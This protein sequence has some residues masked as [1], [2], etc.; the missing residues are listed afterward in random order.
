MATFRDD[1]YAQ[2]N[3]HVTVS[4]LATDGVAAGFSEVAGLGVEVDVIEYRNGNEKENTVRK[5]PGL[6]K[7]SNVVLKRG[8]IGSTD[9]FQWLVDVLD[10]AAPGDVRRDVTIELLSENRQ[11]VAVTWTL[12]KAWPC[13]WEGPTLAAKGRC[14]A[15]ETLELC[16]EG[17]RME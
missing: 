15:I 1:P 3:F 10:G 17:L 16:H 9:L 5:I 2:F 6:A 8:I 14:V 4:G 11:D 12:R 13:K 7:Y